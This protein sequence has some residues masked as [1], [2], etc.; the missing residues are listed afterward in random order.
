[1]KKIS[2]GIVG[3]TGYTGC[4]LMRLLAQHPH[5]DLRFISARAH[6]GEHPN[7][8]F[9]NLFAQDF[10]L[11]Y[12]DLVLEEISA[13]CEVVFFATPHTVAM[14]HAPAL[15][16]ANVRVIDLSADFRL[17]HIDTW[18]KYYGVTHSAPA[19]LDGAVYGLAEYVSKQ[20]LQKAQ[21]VAVPGC[22]PTASLLALLPFINSTYTHNTGIVVDGKSG[23]SGAGRKAEAR[24]LF[25]ELAENTMPYASAGHRHVPEI[26]HW[27]S[28]YGKATDVSVT[29]V[30]HLVPMARGMEVTAYVP[31]KT[32]VTS[33][34]LY[35]LLLQQYQKSDYVRLL[36]IGVHPQSKAVHG[37][38][39]CQIS[40]NIAAG[41]AHAVVMST[42]DNL[43]KGA[44]GQAVQLF[45]MMFDF[46]ATAG[47]SS[48]AIWP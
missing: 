48:L 7:A 37:T 30:P 13:Q 41:G 47:V 32:A 45:N 17:P 19:L 42:I 18:Q 25:S 24:L 22:Y 14:Q 26:E 6:V 46:P 12:S 34:Q 2:V 1:M 28:A 9:P 39:V 40:A 35:N 5:V 29:F 33:E 16:D 4:E 15:L 38:N 10:A 8:L 43:I 21:L 31:L 3:A 27:L 23:I 36:P 20:A 44:S 11:T